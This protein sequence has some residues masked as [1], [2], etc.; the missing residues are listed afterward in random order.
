MTS[1][2]IAFPLSLHPVIRSREAGDPNGAQLP[3][4]PAIWIVDRTGR[5]I[6]DV[7]SDATDIRAGRVARDPHPLVSRASRIV[8]WLQGLENRVSAWIAPLD[9]P[10]DLVVRPFVGV[11]PDGATVEV[12]V[13]FCSAPDDD[14]DRIVREVRMLADEQ[15]LARTLEPLRDRVVRQ[16]ALAVSILDALQEAV[17][18]WRV[19]EELTSTDRLPLRIDDGTVEH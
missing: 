11:K 19:A 17:D 7:A 18:S 10:P 9:G 3:Y 13:R 16:H 4:H 2:S 8:T 15:E 6:A 5:R 1:P 12:G 14:F